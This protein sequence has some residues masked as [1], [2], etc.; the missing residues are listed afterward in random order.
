MPADFSPTIKPYTN[1]GAFR[2]WCQTVLPLVY[3]DS[4]SYYE[5]LNKVVNYLN[6]VISDVSNM[7][8][9]VTELNDAYVRLQDYVNTYFD[10]LDVT[11]EINNKLNEMAADG[12]LTQ[13]I[14]GA[15]DI[16]ETITNWLNEH[17]VPTSP[18][19]DDTLTISGAAADSKTVGDRLA[20]IDAIIEPMPFATEKTKNLIPAD[21]VNVEITGE[22]GQA[23]ISGL[24]LEPGTYTISAKVNSNS[25]GNNCY[26][27]I[28]RD[29]SIPTQYLPA[30]RLTNGV[31]AK[32]GEYRNSSVFTINERGTRLVL[33]TGQ[34]SSAS[35]GFTGSWEDV[36]IEAGTFA[37]QFV[38]PYSAVD[39]EARVGVEETLQ[40]IERLDSDI[41]EID[42]NINDIWSVIDTINDNVEAVDTKANNLRTDVDGHTSDIATLSNN[43][44][45]MNNTIATINEQIEAN[46]V[47]E[48]KLRYNADTTEGALYSVLER[49][50]NLTAGN[51]IDV[52]IDR[53]DGQHWTIGLDLEPG[54]YTLSALV[55]SD[56]PWTLCYF[57]L[58]RDSDKPTQ[59]L[60]ADRIATGSITKGER[61][62]STFTIS[63][64]A[65]RAII[66]A[67]SSLSNSAGYTG[68]WSD[69]QIEAGS[70]ATE[71]VKPFVTVDGEAR[72]RVGV[73]EESVSEIQTELD[74]RLYETDITNIS[75]TFTVIG[76]TVKRVDKHTLHLYGTSTQ[77]GYRGISFTGGQNSMLISATS[78]EKIY[79][80]GKYKFTFAISGYN[81]SFPGI[82]YVTTTNGQSRRITNGIMDIADPFTLVITVRGSENFGTESE[83]TVISLTVEQITMFNPTTIIPDG[84][85]QTQYVRNVLIQHKVANLITGSYQI[86]DLIMPENSSIIGNGESV[87]VGSLDN[88]SLII[89]DNYC[90]VKGVTLKGSQEDTPSMFGTS[91]GIRCRNACRG[92]RIED[93]E[94]KYFTGCGIYCTDMGTGIYSLYISNVGVSYC[95]YGL[96]T[97]NAEYL[98]I[99]ACKFFRNYCGVLNQGGNNKFANCD[100]SGNVQV[101]CRVD[102]TEG[103]NNGHGSF[104]GCTFNH[105]GNNDTD[106]LIIE[107]TGRMLINGCHFS[108]GKIT[109]T[110]TDGNVFSGCAFAI[111]SPI[112]ITGG[113]C[114]LFVGCMFRSVADT[115]VTFNN[116][117]AAR[118]DSCYLRSGA[119][120]NPRA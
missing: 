54:T 36:Q 70:T 73:V 108:Y 82:G 41:S 35:A 33:S 102:N 95:Y 1:Q 49:T 28:Y 117:T 31:V 26:Y 38:P 21:G 17:V 74:E 56:A 97:T 5:L 57:A 24:S 80:A 19:V 81:T 112:E 34:N 93:C 46:R 65:T 27:A 78:P 11:E 16:P 105:A 79:N 84:S 14:M 115:P 72:E 13:L 96:K 77:T 15:V 53:A 71:F 45:T 120:F 55:N 37:T 7:G 20:E 85:D 116:N 111:S 2:F 43:I 60:P 9:N 100:F 107:G 67:G 32:S 69:I 4:L 10:N 106:D 113:N 42:G 63:Q 104:V 99:T 114:S 8:D 18:A 52:V 51:L 87:I 68:T 92:T 3:D 75:N 98:M 86:T 90:T 109:L 44:T 62:S 89:M 103:S 110:N 40:I 25:T 6:N 101:N 30:D 119:V 12:T 94:I 59:W 66:C 118:F 83:P 48:V 64:K 88:T 47:A 76:V 50:K 61:N 22:G 23:Y 39:Y 58:Y 29:A 91:H